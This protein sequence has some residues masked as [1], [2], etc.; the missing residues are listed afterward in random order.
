MSDDFRL[1]AHPLVLARPQVVPPYGWVGHIPFAYLAIDLLRPRSLVELGT[2]SG[3][4]YMAF[5]QAVQV[6]NLQCRCAAVD[7]WEGD[8]HA[9]HYGEEVY[10]ALR[11]RHDPRYD[12]FSRLLR[13]P[14]DQAVTQFA[15]GSIDLLH[16]DGLHT[17]EAVRHDFETWLPKLS[18]R[19]VVLLHDTAEHARGF[20][21]ARF[22]DELLERYPGFAF[23][24]SHGLGLVA[25][26]DQVPAAFVAFLHEANQ[27]PQAIR[28]FFEALAGNLVDA[29]GQPLGAVLTEPL[30]LVC[31]LFYRGRDEAY[32]ESRMLSL[33]VDATDGVLDL[34]FQL[35]VGVSPAYLRVDPA[36][37]AGVYAFSQVAVRRRGDDRW[38]SLPHLPARLGH[39]HG[40]LLQA[41][42]GETVRLACFDDDPNLEF[43]VGSDLPPPRD[44]AGLDITIRVEY[45]LV[46]RDP[47]LY[48]LLELQAESLVGLRQL[49]RERMDAQNQV[50]EFVRQQRQLQEAQAQ[51]LARDIAEQ[52]QAMQT[53]T[54]GFAEQGRQLEHQALGFAHQRQQLQE[55]AGAMASRDELLQLRGQVADLQRLAGALGEQV[56]MQGAEQAAASQEALRQLQRSVDMLLRSG[57]GARIRRLLG[58]GG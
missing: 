4:S 7:T 32:D 9:L 15:A 26:G 3:N 55:L 11:A 1:E 31:Q 38:K 49:S 21:V 20:G 35:P 17:Y 45:E 10:Q 5:C 52:R 18:E 25:V 43:E 13:Q 33:P 46:I 6:L 50:R 14:F 53:L 51:G 57:I 19:A 16:I 29:A 47:A 54:T 36:G 28:G 27:R 12:G 2:H 42:G 30:P 39:V 23:C 34:Q 22:F 40:E 48:R 56:A 37:L 58:R 24:H 41:T 44:D 8:E